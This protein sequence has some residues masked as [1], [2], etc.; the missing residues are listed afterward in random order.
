MEIKMIL[1]RRSLIS[2]CNDTTNIEI[3]QT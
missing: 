2:H 3:H 1:T